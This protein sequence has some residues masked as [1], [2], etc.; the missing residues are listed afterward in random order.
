MTALEEKCFYF[1]QQVD[2]IVCSNAEDLVVKG[3]TAD[4]LDKNI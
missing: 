2:I 4:N 3:N 1:V